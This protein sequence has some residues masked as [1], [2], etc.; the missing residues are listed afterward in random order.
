M[1]IDFPKYQSRK[2]RERKGLQANDARRAVRFGSFKSLNV[3]MA[4]RF[5]RWL[6]V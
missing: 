6:L 4:N 3:E 5:G 2:S 1:I